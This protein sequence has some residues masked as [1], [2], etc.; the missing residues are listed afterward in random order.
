[1]ATC[2]LLSVGIHHSPYIPA[3][4]LVRNQLNVTKCK[5]SA[6]AHTLFNIR[7]RI[8]VKNPLNVGNGKAFSRTSHLVQHQR[9]HTGEKPYDC[10]E[11]GKAFGSTSELI[12]HQR[13]HTGVKP[14]ECKECGKDSDSIHNLFCI[15]GLI[16]VRNP[17]SVKTVARPLFVAHNLLFIANSY[18]C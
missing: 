12:L 2:P 5:H 14:Y 6:A 15:I 7:K 9:I 8:L 1:M 3:V 16:Q 4:R 17:T 11:C 10:K 13:L 18:R